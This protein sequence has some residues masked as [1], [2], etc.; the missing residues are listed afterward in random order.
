MHSIIIIEYSIVEHLF[1]QIKKTL[2]G[3][4]TGYEFQ[5]HSIVVVGLE[6]LSFS[7]QL[8]ITI[9]LQDCLG[10]FPMLVPNSNG[11]WLPKHVVYPTLVHP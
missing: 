3:L 8:I 5:R 2:L 10:I 11:H 9:L 6:Y 1:T 7:G 4:S